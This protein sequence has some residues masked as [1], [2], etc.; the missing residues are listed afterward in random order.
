MISSGSRNAKALL[1]HAGRISHRRRHSSCTLAATGTWKRLFWRKW[2]TSP[3]LRCAL[4]PADN[5]PSAALRAMQPIA[6]PLFS[7]PVCFRVPVCNMLPTVNN[8]LVPCF[9]DPCRR[10]CMAM[11]ATA[12]ATG[13]CPWRTQSWGGN[14]ASGR[15][16]ASKS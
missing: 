4:Q 1:R 7:E 12:A 14:A 8:W 3:N 13:G 5:Q 15:S 6:Q 10:G 9:H 16:A 2:S 11:V